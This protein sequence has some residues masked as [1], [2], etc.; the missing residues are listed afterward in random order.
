MRDIHDQIGASV[1]DRRDNRFNPRISLRAIGISTC[2][3]TSPVLQVV[4][5][6]PAR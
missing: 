4:P 6:F 5:V 2:I 1:Y 3:S